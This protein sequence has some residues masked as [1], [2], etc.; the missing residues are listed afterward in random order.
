MFKN[1]RRARFAR[2]ADLST[3]PDSSRRATTHLSARKASATE[4]EQAEV[5]G[6]ADWRFD[7]LNFSL[8]LDLWFIFLPRGSR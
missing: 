8:S 2:L 6:K 5:E 4:T 7:S 1:P 3:R